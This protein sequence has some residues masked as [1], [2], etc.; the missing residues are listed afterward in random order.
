M[1]LS[2]LS[3]LMRPERAEATQRGMSFTVTRRSPEEVLSL[4][5]EVAADLGLA[6]VEDDP[7]RL[8]LRD[9][10]LLRVF[11]VDVVVKIEGEYGAVAV[12]VMGYSGPG[13]ITQPRYVDRLV[14]TFEERVQRGGNLSEAAIETPEKRRALRLMQGYLRVVQWIPLLLLL[15]LVIVT[16]VYFAPTAF[17]VAWCYLVVAMPS[18]ASFFHRRVAGVGS[19]GDLVPLAAAT[20]VFAVG[21]VLWLVL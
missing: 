4:C 2:S 1:V 14:R 17:L 19:P 6:V 20:A 5:R 16:Q 12:Q 9:P 13:A 21:I 11:P 10:F 18:A 8:R 3:P 15:P 7:S